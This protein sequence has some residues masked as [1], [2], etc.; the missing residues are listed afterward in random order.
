M[1]TG[2]SFRKFWRD[3][4]GGCCLRI[5]APH[6]WLTVVTLM[7]LYGSSVSRAVCTITG[8]QTVS[9]DGVTYRAVDDECVHYV[10]LA[11]FNAAHPGVPLPSLKKT[12]A[13]N[14]ATGDVIQPVLVDLTDYVDCT[15][16]GHSFT[17]ANIFSASPHP[18]KPSRLMTIS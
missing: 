17:D 4:A 3:Q 5:V 7:W 8:G 10:D 18:N 9:C 13:Q 1:C 15:T 14:Y 6:F 2:M 16:T 11:A 12:V